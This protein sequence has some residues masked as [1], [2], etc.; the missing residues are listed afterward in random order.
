MDSVKNI[1]KKKNASAREEAL[2]SLIKCGS[3]DRYSNLEIDVALERIGD[4]MKTEDRALYT[5]L[6]YGVIERTVTL[7]YIISQFSSKSVE[8]LELN[9]LYLLRL[10]VYQLMFMERIPDHAV[11]DETVELTK[12][13]SNR[14]AAG[15]VNAVLRQIIR[16]RN[17]IRYPDKNTDMIGYLSV[18]YGFPAE[19]C[20]FFCGIYGEE[21]TES[22]FSA[23]NR[24][25]AVSLRVNTLLTSRDE[26]VSRLK[27]SGFEAEI[28]MI[29]GSGVLL[30]R[31]AAI[32]KL[33]NFADGECFVQ[34]EAS[35]LAVELLSPKAGETVFDI[36]SCPGGKSFS[37]AMLMENRGRILSFD[38][39]ENK[40]SLVKKGAE[41]LKIDIIETSARD[42]RSF[43][44]EFAE[45]ADRI[46]CDVPCSGLGVIG[47]KP[48][49]RYKNPE[50]LKRLPQIQY[51]ILA[52]A[53]KY[54][55]RGGTMLYSTCTLNPAENE[56][57]M[58][59]FLEAENGFKCRL[60]RTLYPDTD[61]TDGFFIALLEKSLG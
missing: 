36:C 14:G 13:Y 53:A 59:R 48:D 4:K 21:R 26:Y 34:D 33:P 12:K 52:N 22:L 45:S 58:K 19:L 37:A 25:N 50:E 31:S 20:R 49:L 60:M 38:L 27:E 40:L 5:T 11:C 1:E 18:T 44:E 28:S 3:C 57:I 47:K 17:E 39:H 16:K 43:S 55:K 30:S 51:E 32:S 54:L 9:V 29:T 24:R 6:V 61:G 56:G 8:K 42:G 2:R 35:Q 23:F 7:D 15:F 41:R 10:G 46:I